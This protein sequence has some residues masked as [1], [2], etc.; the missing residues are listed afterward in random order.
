M[1]WMLHASSFH[2]AL[3]HREFPVRKSSF[4]YKHR[5]ILTLSI[6]SGT[7]WNSLYL[8]TDLMHLDLGVLAVIHRNCWC[9]WLWQTHA[10]AL[11]DLASL[12]TLLRHGAIISQSRFWFWVWVDCNFYVDPGYRTVTQKGK[13]VMCSYLPT[14][15]CSQSA[16]LE[17]GGIGSINRLGL[18]WWLLI[19]FLV[20]TT[21]CL[22]WT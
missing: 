15:L 19:H 2:V 11:S 10:D 6:V 3:R 13:A 8:R 7:L 18:L 1:L 14:K 12:V 16:H 9:K 4:L 17:R 20:L 21:V 22:S 5:S